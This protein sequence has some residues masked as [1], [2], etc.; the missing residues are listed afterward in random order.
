MRVW[1]FRAAVWVLVTLGSSPAWASTPKETLQT[2]VDAIIRILSNEGLR[3]PAKT[4]ER[5]EAIHAIV[6]DTFD[7]REI[8][9]RALARH[10]GERT[11]QEQEEFVYL[12]ADFLWRTYIDILEKY[13]NE[14]VQYLGE[15]VRDGFAEVNTTILSKGREIAIDYRLVR[16]ESRWR[17][18]D[19]LVEGISL[20][21]NYRAQFDKIILS[22]SF[23]H[24]I[25][26]LRGRMDTAL[27]A[28]R[29][30]LAESGI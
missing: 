24:V 18:Y 29:K 22:K 8:G 11:P 5:R 20:V 3:K 19:V 27:E 2:S 14:S 17:V 30:K 15:A 13:E 9:K 7:F 21:N 23:E 28:E 12:F 16:M 6:V 4:V 25:R 10:W 26:F 1:G